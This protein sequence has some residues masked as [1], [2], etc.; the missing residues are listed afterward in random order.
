MKRLLLAFSLFS[1][2]FAGQAL[3]ADTLTIDSAR[4]WDPEP[5]AGGIVDIKVR[6]ASPFVDPDLCIGCGIC[7]HECPVMGIK[8]IR[9][10]AE[11]ESRHAHH[12][13]SV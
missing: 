10:T 7:E 6:L 3:A 13:I 1:L 8:A 11:N 2:L 12:A 4:P 9:V 5:E